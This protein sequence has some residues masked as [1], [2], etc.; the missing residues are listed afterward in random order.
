MEELKRLWQQV[1]EQ[2]IV[3]AKYHEL[4]SQRGEVASR[5]KELE[6][7]KAEE[8]ADVDRLEKGGL[9]AFFYQMAGRM[10]EKLDAIISRMEEW[11]RLKK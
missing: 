10:E 6:K 4:Q 8:Q 5:L 2:K 11:E 3:Q 7:T 9:A 1:A